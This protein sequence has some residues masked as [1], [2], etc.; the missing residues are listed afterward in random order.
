MKRFIMLVLS[1]FIFA[2]MASC[3]DDGSSHGDSAEI[4]TTVRAFA[5]YETEAY[6]ADVGEGEDTDDPANEI[7]DN[8]SYFE[9]EVLVTVSTIPISPLPASV[10]PSSLK[11]MDYTVRF[12]AHEDSPDVPSRTFNHDIE[13]APGSSTTMSIRLID[14]EDKNWFSPHPLN[15]FDYWNWVL[16]TG[17]VSW[18]YTVEVQLNMVEVL[19]GTEETIELHF[20]LYYFDVA[21][22]CTPLE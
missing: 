5:T 7:C 19:T 2:L 16:S 20:P 10:E 22:D 18:E 17:G 6:T 12:I 14:Q 1:V 11:V 13:I 8:Y 4:F 9:D 15:H 3:S 21:E